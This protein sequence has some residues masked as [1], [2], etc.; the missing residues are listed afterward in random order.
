LHKH[1]QIFT[2]PFILFFFAI[3]GSTRGGRA[4]GK[5]IAWALVPEGPDENSHGWNPWNPAPTDAAV[6]GGRH[7]S[8]PKL[9]A[10]CLPIISPIW[11]TIIREL[12]R[13]VAPNSRF[14]HRPVQVLRFQEF[15]FQIPQ[16]QGT[17]AR[18]PPPAP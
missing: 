9:S 6:L 7:D 4:Q 17:Y 15:G 13:A 1:K 2:S 12:P 8:S 5:G 18:T 10:A 3:L 16:K 14:A 11:R